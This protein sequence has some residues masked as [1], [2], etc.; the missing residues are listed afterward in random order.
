MNENIIVESRAGDMF[1]NVAERAK[2]LATSKRVNAQ[3][4]FNGI[5]CIVNSETDLIMLWKH[6]CDAHLMDWNTVGPICLDYD[7]KLRSRVRKR[8]SEIEVLRIAERAAY[9]AKCQK[10]KEDVESLIAHTPLALSD[11]D[12]WEKSRLANLDGYGG[13][14]IEFAEK[15][16]RIMQVMMN[17]GDSDMKDIT[18]R[19]EQLL[20]YAGITGFQYGCAKSL[21][22][23]YWKYGNM[24]K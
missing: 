20:Y 7:K 16:G 2:E 23:S 14:V 18:E 4:E 6:Y 10:E 5:V 17:S 19:S 24:L 13:A 21:L 1:Q 22:R 8:E 15:W 12:G 9:D 11:V 3:F